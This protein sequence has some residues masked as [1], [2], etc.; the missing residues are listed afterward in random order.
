MELGKDVFNVLHICT[1]LLLHVRI[2]TSYAYVVNN[3]QPRYKDVTTRLSF[4]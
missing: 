1:P 3:I 2:N 4:R